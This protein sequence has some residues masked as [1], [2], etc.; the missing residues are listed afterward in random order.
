M[1]GPGISV[2]EVCGG[3]NICDEALETS[4]KEEIPKI[5]VERKTKI[6]RNTV[7]GTEYFPMFNIINRGEGFNS[8]PAVNVLQRTKAIP[9]RKSIVAIDRTI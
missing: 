3:L 9:R 4:M 7:C 5:T 2:T 6:P 8:S 1:L